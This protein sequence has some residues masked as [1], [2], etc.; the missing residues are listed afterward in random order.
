MEFF[1]VFSLPSKGQLTKSSF[2]YKLK[3]V[4][5]DE[6][7]ILMCDLFVTTK[8]NPVELI[9]LDTVSYSVFIETLSNKLDKNPNG[10]IHHYYRGDGSLG[11]LPSY[12]FETIT[13][14]DGTVMTVYKKS[15]GGTF[16][17]QPSDRI[18]LGWKQSTNEF[19]VEAEYVD[20]DPTMWS[21]YNLINQG[22]GSIKYSPVFTYNGRD[23]I[24]SLPTGSNPITEVIDLQIENGC[25]YQD[26]VTDFIADSFTVD[27]TEILTGQ[28][29]RLIYK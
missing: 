18:C 14:E 3:Q 17:M 2:Y 23:N 4:E 19:V 8:G 22:G 21:S 13:M 27:S 5:I 10:T 26:F 16:R 20:G 29:I 9:P 25:M 7:L 12:G 24:F 1:K 11:V 15:N 6:D 28:K